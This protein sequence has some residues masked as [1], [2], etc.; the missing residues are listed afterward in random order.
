MADLPRYRV[1][2]EEAPFTRV[3]VDYFGPVEVKRGRSV[4]KRYGMVF[5]CLAVRAIHIEKAD[6]LETDSCICAIR[7]F[8]ARRGQVKEV[9]SDNGTNLV[10][11]K[12]ELQEQIRKWNQAQIH[13]E[14]LQDHVDWRFNPPAGSHFGG[15]WERMIRTIRKVMMSVSK[16]QMLTDEAL[17]TLFCEA[18][19]VVNSRPITK[20]S[21]DA[22]DLEA[23]TPNH[24]LL[25]KGK[26]TLPPTLT[27]KTDQYAKRDGDKYNTCLICFGRWT[28]EYLVQ[29]QERQKWLFQ[30]SNLKVGDIVLVVDGSKPRNMWPMGKVTATRPDKNGFV[31]QVEIKTRSTTLVRPVAK[32]CLLLEAEYPETKTLQT[33]NESK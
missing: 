11:A 28:S 21:S 20:V 3:G 31:R 30:K 8:I 10:G 7:R 13:S 32:L 26:P 6:T 25:L 18:E 22:G 14:L 23:L 1:N 4:V 17:Q 15:V 16:E 33:A 12:R 2:P 27:E 24:L 5:T 9:W 29:Q 19:A